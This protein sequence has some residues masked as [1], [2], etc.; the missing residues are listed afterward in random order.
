MLASAALVALLSTESEAKKT[1][2]PVS[3]AALHVT[4]EDGA[5]DVVLTGGPAA[6]GRALGPDANAHVDEI[7]TLL[8][9]KLE[10]GTGAVVE[11]TGYRLSRVN[12]PGDTVVT[13]VLLL[14]TTPGTLGVKALW[15]ENHQEVPTRLYVGDGTLG[16]VAG[17]ARTVVLHVADPEGARL[18][19]EGVVR[20][21]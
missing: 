15:W 4:A 19:V 20:I 3:F 2:E 10:K 11:L 9:P 13:Y 6:Q 17:G 14:E 12:D 18:T 8:T 5:V 1:V 21:P 7:S 16:A